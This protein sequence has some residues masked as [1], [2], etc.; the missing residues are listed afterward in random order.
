MTKKFSHT[1][2]LIIL[3]LFIKVTDI[4]SQENS[5]YN[6]DRELKGMIILGLNLTQVDGDEVYGYKKTG[7]NGGFG[8]VVPIEKRFSLSIETLFNQK[9]A[10]RRYAP[11]ADSS[12][13]VYYNLRLNY[14]EVPFLLNYEDRQTW[15]FGL[16]ISWGRL[17]SMNEIEHGETIDWSYNN[18]PYSKH[19]WNII[20]NIHFRLWEH[21][22]FNLRYA[23]S[24]SK[25]RTREFSN[26]SGSTWTREQY[27]NVISL[28]LM[29]VFNEKYLPPK[30]KI[31]KKKK[32]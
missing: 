9:G 20:A 31:E 21:L 24:I 25:I 10:Y 27:N 2:L 3:I 29:Y 32:K 23:Y 6:V 13:G 18:W 17:V 26:Y 15:N 14:L 5:K 11:I 7:L 8:A 4:F 1:I 16:G 12:D 28:R 19:D 30:T 22:K